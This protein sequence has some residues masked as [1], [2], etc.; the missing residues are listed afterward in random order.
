M[1][2]AQARWNLGVSDKSELDRVQE[3]LVAAQHRLQE[4]MLQLKDKQELMERSQVEAQALQQRLQDKKLQMESMRK[5]G[6]AKAFAEAQ[7]RSRE[8]ETQLRQT[9]KMIADMERSLPPSGGVNGGVPGGVAGGVPGGVSGG[10]RA[11][12]AQEHERRIRY[13]DEWFSTGGVRGSETDRG[14]IYVVHGPPDEIES[15][16]QGPREEWLWRGGLLLRF[17]GPDYKL[18]GAWPQK[19]SPAAPSSTPQPRQQ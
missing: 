17:E 6:D 10:V 15:H 9:K 16:P 5:T 14:R 7:Q 18:V 1:E 3:R 4:S 19:N 8:M 11:D 13:A 2:K 12:D